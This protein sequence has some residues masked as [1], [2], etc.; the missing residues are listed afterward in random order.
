MRPDLGAGAGAD[1]GTGANS[2]DFTGKSPIF[3]HFRPKE[4]RNSRW[5]GAEGPAAAV[6]GLSVSHL[7]GHGARRRSAGSAVRSGAAI[8]GGPH[9][10]SEGRSQARSPARA[11]T[12]RCVLRPSAPRWRLQDPPAGRG[13]HRR[14]QG[15]RIWAPG[16]VRTAARVRTVPTLPENRPFSGI[17]GQKRGATAGGAARKGRRATRPGPQ[18][19]AVA[20]MRGWTVGSGWRAAR[21]RCARGSGAA[22][23]SGCGYLIQF[24]RVIY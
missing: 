2:A 11:V 21:A 8:G 12:V 13:G 23:G 17:F 4:G 3:G 16:P 6:S 7:V 15:G 24:E 19:P 14:T 1:G 18:L 5:S 10:H 9:G 20:S 22:D